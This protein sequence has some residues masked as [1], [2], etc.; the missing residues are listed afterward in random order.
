MIRNL[1]SITGNYLPDSKHRLYMDHNKKAYIKGEGSCLLMPHDM[2]NKRENA[3]RA[4]ERMN[5]D[6]PELQLLLEKLVNE[7]VASGPCIDLEHSF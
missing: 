2:Y 3:L 4:S 6:S 7:K 5:L 1:Y